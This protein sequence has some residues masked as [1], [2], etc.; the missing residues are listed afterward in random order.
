MA[1]RPAPRQASRPATKPAVSNGAGPSRVSGQAT[2]KRAVQEVEDEEDEEDDDFA[3]VGGELDLEADDEEDDDEVEEGDEDEF[4]ELDSG[5]ELGDEDEDIEVD[6]DEELLDDEETG[7]ESGYNT[8]D[9]EDME[10]QSDAPSSS[11]SISLSRSSS[12]KDM[13]TDEKLSRMIAKNTIKPD[14]EVGTDGRLSNAKQG[15]GK[16]VRSKLV[17]GGYKREYDDVEAGYGSESSTEDVSLLG[18]FQA[19]S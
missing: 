3:P 13:S 10:N 9:I 14:D 17:D 18:I 6:S 19:S 15:H 7:S 12:T 2:K 1:P 5:S 11:T 16:L 4:P 8:S